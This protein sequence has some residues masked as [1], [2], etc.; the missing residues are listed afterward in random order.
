MRNMISW[1]VIHCTIAVVPF[2][3][4]QEWQ[5]TTVRGD[6]EDRTIAEA[7]LSYNETEMKELVRCMIM[8]CTDRSETI[9]KRM[10]QLTPFQKLLI[11][12]WCNGM[13][14]SRLTELND[15]GNWN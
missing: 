14:V 15:L 13:G 4:A 5:P 1:C 6:I 8:L 7:G 12:A 11:A 9:E 3:A 10:D 2:L